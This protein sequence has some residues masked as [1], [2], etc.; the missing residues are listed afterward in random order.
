MAQA[1]DCLDGK[2]YLILDMN[3]PDGVGLTVLQK[4]RIENPAIKTVVYSGTDDAAL[5]DAVAEHH[6]DHV[7]RKPV[8]MGEIIGWLDAQSRPPDDTSPQPR[9]DG[10]DQQNQ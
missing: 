5:M 6:P 4:A 1:L 3:L 7:F 9:N 10:D 2:A 8:M